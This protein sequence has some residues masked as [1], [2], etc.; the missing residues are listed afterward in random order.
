MR[1]R[2]KRTALNYII[3][4]VLL[5]IIVNVSYSTYQEYKMIDVL[6]KEKEKLDEEFLKLQKENES[7]GVQIEK[8]DDPEYVASY[9][10][11]TYMLS[12]EGEKIY[13]VP[14]IDK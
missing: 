8:L 7:L 11:G 10:R 3:I 5:G 9:A 4:I 14:N 2:R 1:K 13:Y 12:K 6:T